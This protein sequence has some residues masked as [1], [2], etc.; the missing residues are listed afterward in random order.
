MVRN[1]KVLKRERRGVRK[2]WY[3]L[4][5]VLLGAIY[6]CGK[7][8]L[9]WTWFEEV[10]ATLIAIVTIVSFWLEYNENKLLN[11]A[12]FIIELNEKFIGNEKLSNVEWELEK[13]FVRYKK[14]MLTGE[15]IKEFQEKYDIDGKERQNLVNY[16]V[17]LEGIA[18]LVKN[19]VLHIK[20]ID[21]LMSYRYFIAMNNPIVQELEL[22][23]YSDFYQGCFDI[24]D[25]WVKEMENQKV[26]PPMY[27]EDKNNLTKKRN[28]KENL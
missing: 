26:L 7:N 12:Q 4:I 16:L 3:I 24:Y 18:T 17:H 1:K 5:M 11:E 21:D 27:D 8:F 9:E 23:E 19:K 25:I 14:N 15:Y 10:F 28:S 2:F 20:T 13:Y 6:V 22:L